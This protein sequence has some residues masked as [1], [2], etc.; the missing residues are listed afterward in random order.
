MLR[1]VRFDSSA[2]AFIQAM[3]SGAFRSSSQRY[4]SST[5]VPKKVSG[6]LRAGGAA[7]R[8]ETLTAAASS[9]SSS[10]GG[11]SDGKRRRS[12]EEAD[13]GK[14]QADSNCPMLA[15]RAEQPVAKRGLGC[16]P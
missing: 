5:R 3:V 14:V 9:S 2:C 8:A 11:A 4:G 16:Q 13:M 12:H 15:H 1:K 6:T 7:A 10:A